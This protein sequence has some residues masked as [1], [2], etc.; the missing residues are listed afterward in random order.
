[1]RKAVKLARRRKA[2]W[3]IQCFEE[4]RQKQEHQKQEHQRN[5]RK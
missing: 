1:M 4:E 2:F 5:L 3:E